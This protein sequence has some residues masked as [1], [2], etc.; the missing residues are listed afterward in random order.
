M[1][2]L[3]PIVA[4]TGHRP[5]KLGGYSDAT[6]NRLV[7]LAIAV[8]KHENPRHVITGMALGWDL[9]LAVAAERLDIPYTAAIPFEG[10]EKRWPLHSQQLYDLMRSRAANVHVLHPGGQLEMHEVIKLMYRRD[11]WM[12]DN[13]DVVV[14]LYNGDPRGGTAHTV[15]YA[16]RVGKPIHNYWGSWV[17]YKD[18][19]VKGA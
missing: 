12:V 1:K 15:K 13:A 7:D 5:N 3:R 11:E 8:L 2:G 17:K 16:E 6:F 10:Q 18:R 19:P 14:A 4:G 9:A